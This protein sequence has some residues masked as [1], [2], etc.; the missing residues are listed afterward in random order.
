MHTLA[1]A[2]AVLPAQ[3]HFFQR[4]AFGFG[5]DQF[6]VARAVRLAEGM[7]TGDERDGF[8]IVHRHAG[9]SLTHIA[10]PKPQGRGCRW[11]LRG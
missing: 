2:Q 11:D 9:E 3:S 10:C 8:F 5:S 7:S 6:R 4:G 1:G